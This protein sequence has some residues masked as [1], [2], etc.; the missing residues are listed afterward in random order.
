MAE[1]TSAIWRSAL[2]QAPA[3]AALPAIS[4]A[5]CLAALHYAPWGPPVP[6]VE[7]PGAPA[8]PTLPPAPK[9]NGALAMVAR[10]ALSIRHTFAGRA[11]YRLAPKPL[12]D[13]LRQ[14]L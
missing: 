10:A 7:A 12:V 8:A 4:A 6:A 11:L 3:S 13:A 5:R 14:R 9:P 1:A 2:S